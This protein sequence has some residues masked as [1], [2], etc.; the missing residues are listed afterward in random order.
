M[1][2]LHLLVSM[3]VCLCACSCVRT[4]VCPPP[5]AST[6]RGDEGLEDSDDSAASDGKGPTR[7]QPFQSY[8]VKEMRRRAD[9]TAVGFVF[10]AVAETVLTLVD[11]LVGGAEPAPAPTPVAAD[12]ASAAGAGSGAGAGAGVG[13]VATAAGSAGSPA[14]RGGGTVVEVTP[15]GN[16]RV[17]PGLALGAVPQLV[18]TPVPVPTVAPT[19]PRTAPQASEE[20]IAV[21]RLRTRAECVCVRART[22]CVSAIGGA[23]F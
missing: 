20:A 7:L 6:S 16:V 11:L 9:H 15:A 8:A 18:A 10:G 19:A 4:W 5:A 2:H 3:F 13:D 14:A 12:A 21:R 22:A 1:A 17:V 23:R